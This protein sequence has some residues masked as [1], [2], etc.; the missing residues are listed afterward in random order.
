MFLVFRGKT[1]REK[2]VDSLIF[3]KISS[4]QSSQLPRPWFGI[5]TK[6]D[7]ELSKQF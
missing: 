6:A 5:G 4:V 2:V 7:L 1:Q 3:R